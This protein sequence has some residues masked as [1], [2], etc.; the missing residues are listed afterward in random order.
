MGFQLRQLRASQVE[1]ARGVGPRLP[2]KSNR[3]CANEKQCAERPNRQQ[4]FPIG[5]GMW[6]LKCLPSG[7]RVV[8]AKK[9]TPVKD[10]ECSS[11]AISGGASVVNPTTCNV[12]F[13]SV[14]SVR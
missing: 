9:C 14:S 6:N 3:I 8:G 1:F 2:G 10:P 4:R 13:W 5:L 11:E 12:V 7:S